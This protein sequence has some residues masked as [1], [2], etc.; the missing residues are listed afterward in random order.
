[1]RSPPGLSYFLK[2]ALFAASPVIFFLPA[3]G[4]HHQNFGGIG[5]YGKNPNGGELP[6]VKDIPYFARVNRVSDIADAATSQRPYKGVF[7]DRTPLTPSQLIF[8]LRL[9]SGSYKGPHS[10]QIPQSVSG[11]MDPDIALKLALA[12]ERKLMEVKGES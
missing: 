9:C 1:M 2:E 3:V 7:M 12:I 8:E 4:L 10:E 5:G 11:Q 6:V